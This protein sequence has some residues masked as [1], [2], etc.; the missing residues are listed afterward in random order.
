MQLRK[1]PYEWL[2][3]W[4]WLPML[5]S[6]GMVYATGFCTVCKQGYAIDSLPVSTAVWYMHPL[7]RHVAEEVVS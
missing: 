4:L 7:M 5:S 2:C 1:T 6:A 3:T